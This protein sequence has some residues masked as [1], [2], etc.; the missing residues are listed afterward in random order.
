MSY[1]T[2]KCLE[3]GFSIVASIQLLLRTACYRYC[4]GYLHIWALSAS[5]NKKRML[6]ANLP[7]E[8]RTLVTYDKLLELIVTM[9]Q[10]VNV[11]WIRN[12]K[13]IDFTCLVQLS[14]TF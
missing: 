7:L 10:C 13:G 9:L 1:S 3:V 2:K 14:Y 6:S 4:Y 12:F 5:Y 11:R 8:V